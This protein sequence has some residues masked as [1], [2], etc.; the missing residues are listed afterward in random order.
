MHNAYSSQRHNSLF[1][2][3]RHYVDRSG[4]RQKGDDGE[5]PF[6][7]NLN[8]KKE[9]AKPVIETVGLLG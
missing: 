2:W 7:E 3:P 5:D 9:N 6:G 4:I 1:C 8:E